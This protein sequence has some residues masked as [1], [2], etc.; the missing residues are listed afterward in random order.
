M[1]SRL[2]NNVGKGGFT[3]VELIVAVSVIATIAVV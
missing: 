3:I 1:F 2:R